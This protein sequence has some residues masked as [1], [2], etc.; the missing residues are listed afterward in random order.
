MTV[1]TP[2]VLLVDDDASIRRGIE[3]PLRKAGYDVLGADSGAQA[4]AMCAEQP[5]DVVIT[6]LRMP[7]M[8]GV[9]L[10]QQLRKQDASIPVIVVTGATE[11][12]EAVRAVRAG[13]DDYLCKPFDVEV[14]LLAIERAFERRNVRAEAENLRRQFRERDGEGLQGLVG[15][16]APIQAV[17]RIAR[18][19]ASARASVL[20]TGE[21]GTGKGEV[22]RTIHKLSPRASLP[23]VVIHCSGADAQEHAMFGS[24]ARASSDFV[25]GR[26]ERAGAGTLFLDSIDRLSLDLQTKILRLLQERAFERVGGVEPVPSE[27]RIIASTSK[28]LGEEVANGR[29]REDLFY[30]L[31]VVRIDMPPLRVRGGDVISLA[32]HF[33]QRFAE[34]NQ[35]PVQGFAE[36]ARTKILEYSWPGNV[37][38]LENAVERAVILCE[39][40]RVGAADLPFEAR[41]IANGALRIP[42]SSMADVERYVITKTL[43]SVDGSTTRAADILKLSV[44]TIQYRLGQY[45]IASSKRPR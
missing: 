7:V 9:Q 41:A 19:V 15:S 3:R 31:A 5:P 35:K 33:L 44:R 2:R 8:D 40:D 4:I 16:S 26:I 22:A 38:E 1:R 17:Y 29:F 39:G 6:D 11:V 20:I 18:Q 42:G 27:A 21:S 10:L 28:D 14:L 25:M 24:E 12:S 34:E 36:D 43:E 45:G 37:R 32:M 30:R 23:Y 13:A